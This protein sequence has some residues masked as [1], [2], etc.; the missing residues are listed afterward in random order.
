M[1][2]VADENIPFVRELFSPLGEVITRPGRAIVNKDVRDADVL[3]V[4]SVTQVNE[5]LLNKSLIKFVGTCTIGTDHLDNSYL[6]SRDIV[7]ASAPG[8]NARAVVQYVFAVL[9]M[10]DRLDNRQNVVIVGAG[11]V[12]GALA[13]TLI[14]LGFNVQCI[15]PFLNSTSGLPL[16]NFESIYSADI[17]CVHT[18]LTREGEHPTFH[19]I[20]EKVL[21]K[22]Q[23]D[24]LL[25]NAGRGAVVDNQALKSVLSERKDM[26]VVLDVWE[27]EP[28]IDKALLPMLTLGSPHIAGYSFE[29]R[30]R[31]SLMILEAL[32][33][34]LGLDNNQVQ[35]LQTPALEALA[36][37]PITLP[38]GNLKES[39]LAVY[40]PLVDYKALLEAET[41]L[42]KSFDLL[43]KHYP[44]RREFSHYFCQPVDASED[45]S[46]Y[47]NLGFRVQAVES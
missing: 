28:D 4:R 31:G 13:K 16:T 47:K 46:P 26:Q 38:P 1:K 22:L 6:E 25:L 21:Q 39:I 17:V 7:Y 45:L 30:V 44:K 14:A 42:P 15:D 18:P 37:D 23:R 2:I 11:N 3:L 40:Q 27:P 20:D 34:Y 41:D 24:V 5:S 10:L 29:G 33:H 35:Y 12:G 43:R 36:S 19:L 9:A 8:C 32:C